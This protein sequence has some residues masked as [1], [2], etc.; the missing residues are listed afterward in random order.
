MKKYE[1]YK[2]SGIQWIG[3]VPEHWGVGKIKMLCDS[4]FAG[5]TPST[6]NDSYWNG[7]IPW[8]PSGCCHDCD[9]N[10]A[11]KFITE[12]GYNGSSTKMIP[13]N[14][15]VMAMTGA[16]C[17]QLGYL[18]ID[19]CANQSV[20]AF[21]ENKSRANSRFL[22][23]S[24]WAARK[25]ILTHQTGG[26]QAG[27]NQEDCANIYIPMI[28]LSE[29]QAIAEYLDMKTGKID[30]SIKSLKSQKSDLQKYREALIAETVT[31]GLN[32]NIHLKDSG[33]QWL[34]KVPE[35]WE[36][37]KLKHLITS[38]KSGGTP[39]AGNSAFYAE[40]GTPWVAIGDMSTT[41]IVYDTQ[42]KLSQEGIADKNLTIYPQGTILYS[43]YATIGKVAELGVPACI[44]QA[45][46]AI[47]PKDYMG[48][49][50]FKYFLISL[51]KYVYSL[52]T[53][54]TQANLNA[55]KVANFDFLLPPLS[56]QEAIAD[57]LD[58]KMGKIDEAIASIDTQITDLRAYRTSLITEAVTGK[59]KVSCGE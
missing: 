21:V 59:V 41:P 32:S 36:V 42:K 44:N 24:L 47:E 2:E 17:A 13:A 20:V 53:N 50:Y 23:Y 37:C 46:L 51:E 6:S 58:E 11:P 28:S 40:N 39:E 52:A 22:F 10:S 49:A 4:I 56:E 9:I 16:T 12:E 14:T 19:A 30:E 1:K 45:I 43:I 27:I 26:A 33:I 38:L 3:Q 29:Q 54:S 31:R 18:K 25:E 57:Y 15:T 48:K 5:A 7:N 55:E 34:G 8:I 35:H